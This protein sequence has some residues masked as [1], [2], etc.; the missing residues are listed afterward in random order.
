MTKFA[1]GC[2]SFLQECLLSTF[3]SFRFLLA[4]GVF[5]GQ[6][7]SFTRGSLYHALHRC[8]N[9]YDEIRL[10]RQSCSSH[11]TTDVCILCDDIRLYAFILKRIVF[12]FSWNQAQ[13]RHQYKG[14][15]S[16]N[17]IEAGADFFLFQT[18]DSQSAD[19]NAHLTNFRC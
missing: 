8:V 12:G 17:C 1:Q 3:F 13:Q 10:R 7:G 4:N 19:L 18:V 5:R 9:V 15:N 11:L 2:L 16:F 14:I 6:D